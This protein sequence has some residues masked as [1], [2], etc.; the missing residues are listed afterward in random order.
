MYNNIPHSY[1]QLFMPYVYQYTT[2]LLSICKLA[3]NVPLDYRANLVDRAKGEG[4]L[5]QD[6]VLKHL[7]SMHNRG[8][9]RMVVGFTTTYA[10]SAYHH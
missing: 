2:F 7:C 8:R 4:G 9:E 1:C 3:I 10:I 6:P 5:I